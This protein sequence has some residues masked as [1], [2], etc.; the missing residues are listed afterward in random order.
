MHQRMLCGETTIEYQKET[1]HTIHILFL[2][3]K[4]EA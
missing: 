2:W 1:I 3:Q 4:R